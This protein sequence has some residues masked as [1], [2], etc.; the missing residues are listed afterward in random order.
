MNRK[1]KIALWVGFFNLALIWL[2][3]S[4]EYFYAISSAL[5]PSF[6]GFYFIF[7]AGPLLTIVTPILYLE[8]VFV[9][10]NG[11]V[12]WLLFRREQTEVFSAAETAQLLQKFKAQQPR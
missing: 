5:L 11:M 10:F 3:H 4:F 7:S 6:D 12:L 1:Q 9:L 8:V 2:F